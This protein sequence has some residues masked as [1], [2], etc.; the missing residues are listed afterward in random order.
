LADKDQMTQGL[1]HLRKGVAILGSEP[2]MRSLP[3][4][5]DPGDPDGVINCLSPDGWQIRA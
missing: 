1:E 4:D 2:G 5:P 3:Q